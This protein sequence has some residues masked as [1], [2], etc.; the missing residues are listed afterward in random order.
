MYI[1]SMMLYKLLKWEN[2]PKPKQHEM[3][4]MLAKFL[5]EKYIT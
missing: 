3:Y 4:I 1:L 5:L 2:K